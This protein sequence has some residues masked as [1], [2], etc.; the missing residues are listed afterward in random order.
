VSVQY[1]RIK[2]TRWYFCQT[3]KKAKNNKELSR[4]PKKKKEQSEKGCR[5]KPT[6]SGSVCALSFD[7]MMLG[8][9]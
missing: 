4:T 1:K 3:G 5:G 7:S 6:N 8:E 9:I 2:D